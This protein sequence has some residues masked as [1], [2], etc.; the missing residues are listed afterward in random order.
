MR[1]QYYASVRGRQNVRE[2]KE[3][4]GGGNASRLTVTR[5]FFLLVSSNP[6]TVV[7][8][9]VL[10]VCDFVFALT[11]HCA[12]DFFLR[13]PGANNPCVFACVSPEISTR[14]E[15]ATRRGAWRKLQG[16][17]FKRLLIPSPRSPHIFPLQNNINK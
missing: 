16:R 11:S 13:L 10:V 17:I 3:W 4:Q 2:R 5:V 6:S 12:E 8:P 1:G 15:T 9:V 7:V 14:Q